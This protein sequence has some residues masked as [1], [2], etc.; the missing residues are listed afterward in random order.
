MKR[1]KYTRPQLFALFRSLPPCLVGMEACASAHYIARTL[2]EM[3]HDARLM[4]AQ[5]VKPYLRTQKN[6]FLD[7]EA[8]CEAVQRPTMRLVPIKT[9]EQLELQAVHRVRD[10]LVSRRTAVNNQIRGLL[11]EHGITMCNGRGGLHGVVQELLGEENSMFSPAM[12]ILISSLWAEWQATYAAVRDLSRE[13]E[14]LAKKDP[15]CQRLMTVPGVGPLVAT[16]MIA[17]VA[18]GSAFG[19]G[20]DFAAWLGLV[21][22]QMSTGGK[23]HLGG[24]TKRGNTYLRRMFLHGARSFKLNGNRS[25][26]MIGEWLDDL[27]RRVHKNVATVALANKLARIAWSVLANEKEYRSSAC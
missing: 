25:N 24:I 16:A 6:D 10:R 1:R 12:R 2:G 8:I 20:R 17:A 15:D 22:R 19:R 27:E 11:V 26:H 4:L 7:A 18:D 3:G 13:L 21:P 23:T 5:Y 9:R 14:L